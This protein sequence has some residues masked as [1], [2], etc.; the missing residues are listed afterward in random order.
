MDT[1]RDPYPHAPVTVTVQEV[2]PSLGESTLLTIFKGY[3]V[4]YEDRGTGDV[5]VCKLQVE[6][7]KKSIT[8]MGALACYSTCAWKFGSTPCGFGLEAA[9]VT[10]TVTSM[11]IGGLSNRIQVT[12]DTSVD[13]NPDRWR[14]GYV[15]RADGEGASIMIRDFLSSAGMVATLDLAANPPYSNVT[16]E[17]TWESQAV[18]VVPGCNKSLR[19]C[20][21]HG[22]E[23]SF[24]GSGAAMPGYN[25]SFTSN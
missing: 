24:G 10:G 16:G 18:T 23:E 5:S 6:G 8:D 21:I 7:V 19:V 11:N 20:R 4:K 2:E 9:K 15:Q 12:L 25:P 13:L 1:L 3:V 22:R 14:R 17:N